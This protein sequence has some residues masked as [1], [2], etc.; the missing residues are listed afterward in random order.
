MAITLNPI[1]FFTESSVYHYSEDNKPLEDLESNQTILK[2]A[3]EELQ[4]YNY[5]QTLIGN[6][7]T[8]SM[9]IPIG[10]ISKFVSLKVNVFSVYNTTDFSTPTLIKQEV[11]IFGKGDG[12]GNF[13]IIGS[14]TQLSIHQTGPNTAGYGTVFSV[15][16]PNLVLNYSWTTSLNGFSHV[17]VQKTTN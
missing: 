10:E 3:I 8:L 9:T 4:D 17:T 13:T 11:S 14:P 2:V 6:L 15:S 7:A 16:G 1:R 12:S 5:S